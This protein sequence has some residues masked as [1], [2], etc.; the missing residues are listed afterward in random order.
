MHC[1]LLDDDVATVLNRSDYHLVAEAYGGRGF[2]L[3]R[4]EDIDGILSGAKQAAR[5]GH[6][7]L[8]NAM[9][10]KTDFRKGSISM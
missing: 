5:E 9:I 4:A 7:V 8:I 6:P 3:E 10:G 2:L 1:S